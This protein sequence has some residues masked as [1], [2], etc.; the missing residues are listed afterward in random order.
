METAAKQLFQVVKDHNNRKIQEMLDVSNVY[1]YRD[2]QSLSDD[3]DDDHEDFNPKHFPTIP[4]LFTL[5]ND[6][7]YF[8]AIQSVIDRVRSDGLQFET[9][10][11]EVHPV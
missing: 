5:V 1:C 3:T 10:I 9:L 6:N 2:A 7:G 11:Q 4:C 8:D